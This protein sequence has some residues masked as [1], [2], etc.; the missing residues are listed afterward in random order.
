MGLH[1]G[2]QAGLVERLPAVFNLNRGEASPVYIA[3]DCQGVRLSPLSRCLAWLLSCIGKFITQSC[4]Q[5]PA[6]S[7]FRLRCAPNL[8][9]V[10]NCVL[11]KVPAGLHQ[12][13]RAKISEKVVRLAFVLKGLRV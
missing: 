4:A 7:D 9:R 2:A 3:W 6:G 12:A 10:W 13:A 8:A 11:E 5:G 1:S